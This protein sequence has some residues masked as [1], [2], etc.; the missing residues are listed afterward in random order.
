MVR[1]LLAVALFTLLPFSAAAQD[2]GA[3]VEWAKS[4]AVAIDAEGR[5][6]RAL[7]RDLAS[8]RL[9]GVGESVHDTEPF[10]S[11]RLQ[12]LQDLV[13]RHN[14]T[15]L[16]LESGLPEVMA[17]DDY[18]RGKTSKIDLESALPGYFGPL[19]GPTVEWI[20]EWNRGAGKARP[21]GIY[22]ADLSGRAGSMVPALDRL[23]QLT[24]GDART[25]AMI[26]AIRPVAA[27]ISARW[28]K[29]TADKYAPLSADV[30]NALAGNVSLLVDRVTHLRLGDKDR[31]E[32]ARQIARLLQ[33]AE[34][35]LRL[36]M[37]SPAVPRDQALAENTLWVLGRLR[38]GERAVYWAHN[39][40][41]QRA[42]VK[43]SSLPPGS[44]I[45]SGMR[46]DAALGDQ[47]FAV[48]TAYGGPSRDEATEPVAG[49]VDA[50]LASVGMNAFLL[51]LRG[52]RAPAVNAWMAGE[53]PMRFQAGHLTLPLMPAF[54]AVAFF[55]KAKSAR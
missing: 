52:E 18:V 38:A 6:F 50:A 26:D 13:R 36:G 3:F 42:P 27:E 37:F 30:K 47:Y 39:A 20:R 23:E 49:S 16:V 19:L 11:F 15:A 14:V 4:R 8:V 34:A 54:D 17:V 51:P 12:L 40:H 35:G 55:E 32:W 29:G 5:A 46:F 25:K 22:G 7:D 24:A 28:W 2:D 31:G 33:H 10:Q 1:R 41:V 21:V 48:G 43:G 53:R 45:G 9:I 44:F